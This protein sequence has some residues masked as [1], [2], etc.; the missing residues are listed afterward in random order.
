MIPVPNS[1]PAFPLCPCYVPVP[2]QDPLSLSLLLKSYKFIFF[3]KKKRALPL[4][5]IEYLPTE[6]E[7]SVQG[8][9]LASFSD[10]SFK[11]LLLSTC[12][13]DGYVYNLTFF[14]SFDQNLSFF[15][16]SPLPKASPFFPVL[17]R[18]LIVLFSL[19]FR[20]TFCDYPP[21]YFSPLTQAFTPGC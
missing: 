17:P 8:L 18:M 6:S 19:F 10:F 1:H 4:P 16:S 7:K 13:F 21:N 12:H 15:Q 14:V 20:P 11:F 9:S 2:V 3:P 5:P